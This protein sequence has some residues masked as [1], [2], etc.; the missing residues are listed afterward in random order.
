VPPELRADFF[1]GAW[2]GAASTIKD[3]QGVTFLKPVSQQQ[4]NDALSAVA[5]VGDD[6][7]RPGASSESWTHGSSQSRQKWFGEGFT[8][9]PEACSTFEVAK[10]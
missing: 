7:I 1:A 5:A 10:P 8:G 6:R 3:S 4:I 2:V 9:G